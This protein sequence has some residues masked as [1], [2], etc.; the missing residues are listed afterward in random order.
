MRVF[1]PAHR[2]NSQGLEMDM[3]VLAYFTVIYK[4]ECYTLDERYSNN[5]VMQA[6]WFWDQAEQDI[7][8]LGYRLRDPR[9]TFEL[10]QI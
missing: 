6:L 5:A 3:G 1:S 4:S 9:T 2:E 7:M 10:P 8:A